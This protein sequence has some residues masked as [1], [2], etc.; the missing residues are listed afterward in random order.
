MCIRDRVVT[1]CRGLSH[2]LVHIDKPILKI[3]NICIHLARDV[4]NQFAPNKEN[5]ILPVLAT[6][7]QQKL[8]KPVSVSSCTPP[9]TAGNHH[10]LL[11]AI[12][13]EAIGC[14]PDDI[15]DFDLHLADTQPA[16][17]GG[18]LDE[19]IFA[20]RLDNLFNCYTGLQGLMNSLETLD[21]DTNIRMVALYDNEEVG[22]S[23]VQGAGSSFTEFVMRRLS[24]G[25][26]SVAYEEAI[27]KSFLVSADQ[28]HC[29]LSLIHISEPTR[30][31]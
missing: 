31:Y 20:A 6:T 22:S 2:N 21:S 1:R 4:H 9:S 11:I 15:M 3:P 29:V 10:P 18:A 28:A 7:V 23:S 26:S 13:S 17:I 5:H 8:E 19:F 25:G 27:P 14:N 24:V 16:V 12:L 30:P